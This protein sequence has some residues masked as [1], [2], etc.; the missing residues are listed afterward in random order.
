MS[1]PRRWYSADVKIVCSRFFGLLLYGSYYHTT[2][3]QRAYGY[4]QNMTSIQPN[5]GSIQRVDKIMETLRN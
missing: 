2:H 3:S 4:T 5:S 1:H